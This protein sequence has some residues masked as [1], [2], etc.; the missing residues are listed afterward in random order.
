MKIVRFIVDSIKEICKGGLPYYAWVGFLLFLIILGA[1]GYYHEFTRELGP[2]SLEQHIVWP[3]YIGNFAFFVGVAAAAVL[4]VIPAYVY[5]FQAIKE[6][7]IYGE[8]MA[9]SAIV[10]V[11][12]SIMVDVGRA[13]R[14]W[15]L[16][17]FL[18]GILN[19]PASMLS[20][21]VVVLNGYMILNI[22][23]AIYLIYKGYTGEHP[24][25]KFYV[26]LILLSIPFAISIHTVTAF[27]F[28]GLGA[29]PYWNSAILAPRFLASA[30]CS[31]PSLMIIALQII[32][33][34]GGIKVQDV[35]LFKIA[36]IMAYAMFFNLFLFGAEVFKEYY[37]GSVHTAPM[38]YLMQGLHGHN[39]MVPWIWTAITL[40]ITAFLIFIS[41][42]NIRSIKLLN[43]GCVLIFIAV[44]IEKGHAFI[45]PGFIP[46]VLGEIHEY[47]PNL[48]EMIVSL[49]VFALG[50]LLFT[51]FSKLVIGIETGRLKYNKEAN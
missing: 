9:F 26:P 33:R 49:G 45:T 23:I 14:F 38:E 28:N 36:E 4:L 12:G 11:L 35:A 48:V 34:Y 7:A 27:I 29:R 10:M 6:I 50:L 25:K 8:I 19:L 24:N 3:I 20:W 17:P 32:R 47:T 13:D 46:G 44:W 15:H 22:V 43:I 41:L 40:D 16:L 31:G 51:I 37:T 1:W 30:F 42:R 5:H 21:D 18:G 2:E 39:K